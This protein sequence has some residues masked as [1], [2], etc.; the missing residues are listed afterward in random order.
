MT[1]MKMGY[2]ISIIYFGDYWDERWRRCRQLAR[3][4]ELTWEIVGKRL[5]QYLQN[6]TKSMS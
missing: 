5:N 1:G 3:K 4:K 2:P 6:L